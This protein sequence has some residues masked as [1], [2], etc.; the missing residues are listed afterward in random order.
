MKM[1]PIFFL[2]SCGL[3]FNPANGQDKGWGIYPPNWWTGMKNRNLQL[4]V[5]FPKVGKDR[6]SLNY[7]GVLLKK[8][9]RV[10]NNNYLFLDLEI[11]PSAHPGILKLS[12]YNPAGVL[13]SRDYELQRLDPKDGSKRI[14][15]V[16]SSDFIY[17]LMPDR[18]A[19]GD[20]TNDVIPWTRDHV[21]K[22]DSLASRQG[23][24]IQGVIDHLDYL[25]NLGVT[26]LWLTPVLF[27]DEFKYS[28]H[29]Y[30]ATDNYLVDPRLG[31]NKKYHEMVQQAHKKNLKVIQD[32]VLNHVGEQ[33]WFV[34]DLPMKDWLN[35]WPQYTNT[36]Y[37]TAALMDPHGADTD[38]K[39]MSNGWFTQ[40]MPDLNQRNP[41]VANFLI[42]NT[43]WWTEFAGI[44][45]FRID[46][47]PYCDLDFL[48]RWVSTLR[49]Q[50][51]RLTLFGEVWA[52]SVASQAFFTRNNFNI[53]YRSKLPGVT[54]FQMNF[55]IHDALN[56]PFSGDHGVS[57]L[58]LTLSQDFLYKNPMNNVIFLDN[59]DMTRIFSTYGSD[60]RKFKSGFAW[61]LTERGIPQMYYG[62]EILMKGID[63]PDK[64]VR[65]RFPGGWPHD[66]DNKFLASGRTSKE[67]DA[68]NYIRTLAHFRLHNSALKTGEMMQFMPQGGIYV[69]FRYDKQSTVMIVMN[70]NNTD[71]ELSTGR[72]SERLQGFSQARNIETGQQLNQLA[73]LQIPAETTLVLELEK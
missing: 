11:L 19:D 60:I 15:G 33:N 36:S 71:K 72:F 42:E 37:S 68:F 48:N 34:Q 12:F 54:D 30:A 13:T 73:N 41:F 46:T 31:T 1:K 14:V 17:L 8:V 65:A 64:N 22:L 53:P 67:N 10:E 56:Q 58:Y 23:G 18:F 16:R 69:Y 6:V 27:N 21:S 50:F 66:P 3:F 63:N 28:Y 57:R 55:A 62:D 32:I 24:D 2:L 38:R 47:W 20:S 4:L 43:I 49:G 5:H 39:L 61:L 29:G 25:K 40:L 44:D 70:S 7:S 52:N 59:H 45:G 51:P 35:Q 26:T 9:N